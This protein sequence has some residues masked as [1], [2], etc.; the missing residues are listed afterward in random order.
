MEL[1]GCR[2][3][4]RVGG[5][6]A[7]HTGTLEHDVCLDFDAAQAGACIGGEER[8]AGTGGHDDY[9]AGFHALDGTPFIVEFTDGFHAHGGQ[10][11]GF[12][13][14]SHQGGT[15][16][17]A[18]DDG[19][20]HAHLVAFH[21]V[22]SLVGTAQSAENVSTAYHDTYLYSQ[23]MYFLDLS[24]V[25]GKAFLVDAVLLFAHQALAAELQ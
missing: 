14:G 25:L 23:S 3:F 6:D 8:I 15:K 1:R 4:L 5:I 13:T 11:A 18:V 16:G 20:Q 7:V 2:V 19:C 10:Y 22:E 21:T 24:C 9:F 17:K 12:Y